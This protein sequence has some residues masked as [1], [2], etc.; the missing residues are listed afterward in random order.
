MPVP[1][2]TSGSIRL[3]S[4]ASATEIAARLTEIDPERAAEFAANLTALTD[5]LDALDAEYTDALAACTNRDVVTS[6]NA[7]GYLAQRYDLTQVGISGLSPENEPSPADLAAVT[8]FVRDNGVTT[9]YFE[10]LVS[11]ALAETLAAETG[12]S[13]AVLDPIEGLSDASKGSD[14]LDIMRSNLANLVQGQGCT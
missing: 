10:T 5:D 13:T 12:A 7:F 3:V 1:T 4:P 2:R 6:H 8:E 9:I 14:Y 11:P